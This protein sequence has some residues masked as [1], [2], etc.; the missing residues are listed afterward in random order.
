MPFFQTSPSPILPTPP[1]L[2]G[3]SDP[4]LPPKIS[5]TLWGTVQLCLCGCAVLYWCGPLEIKLL[6][7]E[8]LTS[9]TQEWKYCWPVLAVHLFLVVSFF[10]APFSRQEQLTAFQHCYFTLKFFAVILDFSKQ[11]EK[12]FPRFSDRNTL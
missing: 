2:W 6:E 12:V 5:K 7:N 10:L 1:C 4:P 3:K 9:L 11:H 8:Q